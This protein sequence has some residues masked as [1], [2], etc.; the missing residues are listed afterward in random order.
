VQGKIHGGGL[1]CLEIPTTMTHVSTAAK[2]AAA[3]KKRLQQGMQTAHGVA[4][5]SSTTKI[6]NAAIWYYCTASLYYAPLSLKESWLWHVLSRL[7]SS[8]YGE[9]L[10]NAKQ[11]ILSRLSQMTKYLVMRECEQIGIT[12]I[13]LQEGISIIPQK[14]FEDHFQI[15]HYFHFVDSSNYLKDLVIYILW[16]LVMSF[17]DAQAMILAVILIVFYLL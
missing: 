9:E 7:N 15:S 4:M 12:S 14:V 1:P 11:S 8:F 2:L 16:A 5:V 6:T 13:C 3:A 17:S 10:Q